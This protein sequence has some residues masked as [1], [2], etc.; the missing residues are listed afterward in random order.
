MVA[1]MIP[2]IE[3]P[4]H[5][6]VDTVALRALSAA[7]REQAQNGTWIC[8]RASRTDGT[9]LVYAPS[10]G[11]C[12]AVVPIAETSH[13]CGQLIAA[14]GPDAV[15]AL[16]EE[17]EARR[18]QV[19]MLLASAV[20]HP[21]EHPTMWRAWEVAGAYDTQLAAKATAR[22][23]RAQGTRREFADPVVAT[24]PPPTPNLKLSKAQEAL[25]HAIENGG[26]PKTGGEVSA[27]RALEARGLI[28]LVDD[29]YIPGELDNERWSAHLTEAGRAFLAHDPSVEVEKARLA[30]GLLKQGTEELRTTMQAYV[31]DEVERGPR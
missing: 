25:L 26:V 24:T 17:L 23:V 18:A 4:K 2:D 30:L 21:R 27:A 31:A 3:P 8:D 1:S 29:G 16:V 5:P 22:A 14:L 7:A 15:D 28:T 19:A 9:A 6:P 12:R 20:P 11:P 13:V 10:Y